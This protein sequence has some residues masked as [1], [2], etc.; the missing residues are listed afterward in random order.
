MLPCYYYYCYY[1]SAWDVIVVAAEDEE[2][3]QAFFFEYRWDQLDEREDMMD[4]VNDGVDVNWWLF[5]L[6][7]ASDWVLFDAVAVDL[8]I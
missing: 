8:N 1:W 3:V 6:E 2:V 7:L 4:A 5:L